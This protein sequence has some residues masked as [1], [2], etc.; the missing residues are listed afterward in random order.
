MRDDC[1]VTVNQVAKVD[2]YPLPRIDDLLA[3]LGGAKSFHTILYFRGGHESP[4]TPPKSA[5]AYQQLLLDEKS[6]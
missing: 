3:L 2:T 1:K 4:M 6:N 5:H